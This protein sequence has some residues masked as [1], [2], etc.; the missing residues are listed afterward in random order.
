MLGF[1]FRFERRLQGVGWLSALLPFVAVFVALFVGAIIL[2]VTGRD[3][4]G[5][6]VRLFQAAFTDRGALSAT[7]L[8]A[9]PLIFTGLTAAMAFRIGVWNIG[10]DGQ[11]MIGALAA[12]FVGISMGHLG[13]W[14]AIPL[15][16]LAGALGGAAWG[17]VPAYFRARSNTSEVLTTLMLNY[18]APLLLGYL[19]FS[20]RSYW[21]DLESPSAKVFPQGKT[22]PY[23]AFWPAWGG[24]VVVPFG[25]VLAVALA[26]L[27]QIA[28]RTTTFG[29]KVSVTADSP[30]A[31]EY[32]GI[33]TKRVFVVV[34]LISAALAG[35][36]GASQVGD[37]AY[38]VEPR[39][40]QGAAY[41]YTGIAVAALARYNPLG[42]IVASLFLGGL[43]NANLSLQ[44]P[45]LPLGLLG[46]IQGLI[47]L[48]VA[49]SEINARFRVVVRSKPRRWRD[50]PDNPPSTPVAQAGEPR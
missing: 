25:F 19:I 15:M 32:A 33:R 31:G 38:R 20:S 22:I 41:G 12:S 40:L 6:Y 21:R 26:F 34:F 14:V 7:I 45:D 43:V 47:L 17:A 48:I 50:P 23:E 8:S 30:A 10:G 3:P 39:A 11:L 44:G 16:I 9:T 37:F 27:M 5:G 49:A 1:E 36:A 24:D 4:I 18:L 35:L 29:F 46:V 42:V 28:L 13:G 2:W